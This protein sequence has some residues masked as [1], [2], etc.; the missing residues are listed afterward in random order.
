MDERTLSPTRTALAL[1]QQVAV[2]EC[3]M[4]DPAAPRKPLLPPRLVKPLAIAFG[5]GLLLFL[6]L[7][8][9]QRND[10]DF[11]RAGDPETAG[12]TTDALPAPLPADVAS[13]D[14]NA[15]GL[16]LPDAVQRAP[17]APPDQARIIN[18]PPPPPP[19]PVA[20]TAPAA[21]VASRGNDIPVPISQPAP[22]YPQEALRRDAGGTVRVRV[23]VATDGSVD[24]LEVAE[25]SGN[26]YLDRAAMEAVRRW[27]FQPAVRDGQPV[28]ADVVVPI[29][30]NPGG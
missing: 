12:G 28:V 18:E 27:R 24:R 5:V 29:V 14:G 22:R 26:R 11:F 3:G 8:L 19:Q 4:V 10:T 25:S 9:E 20:P 21:P 16:R 6:L 17:E 15:S 1:A 2:P 7:W 23:T 30:F 13:E